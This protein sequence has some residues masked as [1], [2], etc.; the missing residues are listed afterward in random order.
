M[1]ILK[2]VTGLAAAAAVS[3]FALSASA[4]NYPERNITMVIPFAAGG[5]T[6]TVA[7]LVAE[8]MSKDLG[9]QIIVENVGG[10][11]G[12]LGAGRVAAADADG[13]TVLLHHI[14]MATSATLY[15]KLAYDTLN[16]FEYVGLV[17]EVPMTI[18]SRKNLET[19]DLKD[20]IEYA[21]ANKDKVTVANAGI[22]AA[23]HLCGMLFMSAIETPLVTVPY[24]GTGPAM[25][26]L[27]GGQVDIMCDQTTNTTKQIQGG[28]V[29]AYAVTTAK[30]LDVLP[31][32]PTA[33]EAGLSNFEVGIWHGIYTPKGTPAEIN[34]KLSKS[35]QVAL[36]DKNVA[37]RFAELGTTP[38][39]E[40]DA[41][42]AA[43]KAK[44]E[45]EIARWKPVIESAGQY[46]D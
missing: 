8:A 33:A 44:L 2:T 26:D 27:L 35:L 42:P 30:R 29:K 40:N 4:Q 22:G 24:K 38:S 14:G 21:K 43:L 25:T 37:A 36:K 1:K 20:L 32:V 5:P 18:L 19:K 9:R 17:T 7:R 45:S 10:A 6:D 46:A 11:G 3:L 41:T 23:S 16:A 39:A 34:E 15:R 12:T 13:Y 31:D 28:T